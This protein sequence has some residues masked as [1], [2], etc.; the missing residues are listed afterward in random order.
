[1]SNPF[2][3][4]SVRETEESEKRVMP[5]DLTAAQNA[6]DEA[7]GIVPQTQVGLT[8]A[9]RARNERQNKIVMASIAGIAAVLI[10][11]GILVFFLTISSAVKLGE[12]PAYPGASP[13][14]LPGDLS[15]K[16]S[17]VLKAASLN[18]KVDY[19]MAL[20]KDD[21]AKVQSYYTTV[22]KEKEWVVETKPGLQSAQ[23]LG[24][25]RSFNSPKMLT[26]SNKT[27]KDQF[28]YVVTT[29]LTDKT[30]PLAKSEYGIDGKPGETVI[31]LAKSAPR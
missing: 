9:E 23:L 22:M 26:F 11:G 28:H 17:D 29:T 24:G 19:E 25:L 6:A 20:S 8:D 7:E 14:S 15:K 13:I 10:L 18:L 4:F 27:A 21:M 31:L 3:E 30:A 1:M 12:L 16:T 2:R 5:S